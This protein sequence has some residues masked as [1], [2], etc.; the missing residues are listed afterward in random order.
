MNKICAAIV[1]LTLVSGLSISTFA[2]K[3]RKRGA[4]FIGG[5]ANTGAVVNRN[6]ARPARP[7][8][9]VQSSDLYAKSK[10]K[11]RTR[12]RGSRLIGTTYGGD[13]P[14]TLRKGVKR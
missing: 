3:Q 6:R 7:H 1:T 11:S 4:V 13:G 10:S 12:V 8:A 5:G 9:L 14:E 2:Q